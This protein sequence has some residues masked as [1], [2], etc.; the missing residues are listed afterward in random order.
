MKISD[1]NPSVQQTSPV[2]PL[3]GKKG[4]AALKATRRDRVQL[5]AQ[6]KEMQA[7]REAVHQIPD[8]DLEK[9]AR[10]KAEIKEGRY[11]TDARE[12]ASK[13]M[14]ESLIQNSDK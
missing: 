14:M 8:I 1:A 3:K 5:S 11:R 6:A 13:M 12:V 9:V 4:A 7:A 2:K 10:I